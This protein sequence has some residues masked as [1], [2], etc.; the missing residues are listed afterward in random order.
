[1]FGRDEKERLFEG[2]RKKIGVFLLD[3]VVGA[4]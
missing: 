3:F 2:S 1:M 4:L